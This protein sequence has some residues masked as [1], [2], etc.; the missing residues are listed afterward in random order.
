MWTNRAIYQISCILR[1]AP[2]L[3]DFFSPFRVCHRRQLSGSSLAATWLTERRPAIDELPSGHFRTP[4]PKQS[5]QCL[6]L[7]E[8]WHPTPQGSGQRWNALVRLPRVMALICRLLSTHPCS[9]HFPPESGQCGDGPD[10]PQRVV[11]WNHRLFCTDPCR[12]RIQWG[13]GQY[14]NVPS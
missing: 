11:A 9:R 1:A 10:R 3:L 13:S 12:P 14:L 8:H 4:L 5:F 6:F 7:S 2:F